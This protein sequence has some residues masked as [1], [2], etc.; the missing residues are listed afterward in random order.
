MNLII[1]AIIFAAIAEKASVRKDT[2]IKVDENTGS[3]FS[4]FF[5]GKFPTYHFGMPKIDISGLKTRFGESGQAIRDQMAKLNSYIKT[6]FEK[7]KIQRDKNIKDLKEII[8]QDRE[9]A[10]GVGPIKKF[11]PIPMVIFTIVAIMAA[12]IVIMGTIDVGHFATTGTGF[13]T[14]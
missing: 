2:Q 4:N 10:A 13:F 5:D 9:R 1:F 11:G 8:K 12:I 6:R 7:R 14:K 3:S